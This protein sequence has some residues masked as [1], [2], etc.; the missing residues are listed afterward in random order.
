MIPYWD[1]PA[2]SLGPATVRAFGLMVALGLLAG[3]LLAERKLR[4][5]GW[6]PRLMG[7]ILVINIVAILVGGHL[8]HVLMYEP[9]QLVGEGARFAALFDRLA[10]GQRPDRLPNLLRLGE[11][12]SSFG[13]FIG[14]AVLGT[15]WVRWRKVTVWP[16]LDSCMLGFTAAWTLGRIGCFLTHDHPGVV[17][18]FLLGVQGTC[19]GDL[20][21]TAACH[22]LGLYEALWSA[23]MF[24]WFWRADRTPRHPGWFF[25]WWCVSYGPCRL[26]LDF[27][28]HPSGDTR[29]LGLTP[30][31]YGSVLLLVIGVVVLRV[32]KDRPSMRGTWTPDP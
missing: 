25:G 6:D 11:G 13:G 20:P 23:A 18:G 14:V 17:T 19:P 5:D 32:M 31:Q 26:A 22:P 28:R 29:Y 4:R 10:S 7:P 12:L 8:G 3:V 16:Y 24:V 30:A 15:I 27:L 9:E 21:A 2:L 1:P